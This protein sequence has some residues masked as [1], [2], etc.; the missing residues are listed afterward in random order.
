VARVKVRV[1]PGARRVGVLGRLAD[2]QWKVGVS[3]PPD[4]GAANRA[5]ERLL[6]EAL[7]ARGVRVVRGHASRSKLVEVDGLE[8]AEVERRLE[9]AA[10]A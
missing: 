10:R 9:R 6:G 3:A 7:G 2:G 8:E 1:H 5:L 4:G